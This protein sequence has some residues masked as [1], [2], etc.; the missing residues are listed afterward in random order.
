[1]AMPVNLPVYIFERE[2]HGKINLDL[3]LGSQK[4]MGTCHEYSFTS[5]FKH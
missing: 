2:R 1:M 5:P 3:D 4:Y